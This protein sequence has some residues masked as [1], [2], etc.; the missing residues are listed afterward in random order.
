MRYHFKRV[1]YLLLHPTGKIAEKSNVEECIFVYMALH[2]QCRFN[3]NTLL[4][5]S[6]LAILPAGQERNL[7]N[8]LIAFLPFL[9]SIKIKNKSA[10]RIKLSGKNYF[11]FLKNFFFRMKIFSITEFVQYPSYLGKELP[12]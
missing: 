12:E 5:C 4:Q 1:T 9:C 6:F 3:K 2:F 11:A 10:D 8:A 7:V